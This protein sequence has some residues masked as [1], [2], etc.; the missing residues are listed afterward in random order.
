MGNGYEFVNLI[1]TAH[2]LISWKW[3]R[4]LIKIFYSEYHSCSYLGKWFCGTWM[5]NEI[6]FG[7]IPPQ[8]KN[9]TA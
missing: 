7:I 6:E 5:G 4:Y 2:F 9:R 1:N 8:N 3:Q